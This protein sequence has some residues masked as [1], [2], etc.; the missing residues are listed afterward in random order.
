MTEYEGEKRI[1]LF[2]I[3]WLSCTDLIIFPLFFEISYTQKKLVI[4]LNFWCDLKMSEEKKNLASNIL[5]VDDD[6][7]VCSLIGSYLENSGYNSKSAGSAKEMFEE[8]EKHSF[9]LILLDLTLPDED[10]LVLARKLRSRSYVPLIILT[11]RDNIDDKI[12]ALEIG[13]D[14]FLVKSVHPKEFILRVKNL[15]MRSSTNWSNMPSNSSSNQRILE[16]DGW[17]LDTDGYEL[18]SPT[19]QLVKMT[20]TEIKLLSVLVKNTGRVLSRD[21]LLDAIS[22]YDNSPSERMIDAFVSRIRRKISKDNSEASKIVTITGVG[23][24]FEA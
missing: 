4:C 1:I 9:D 19:G 15:L 21:R 23:Y 7:L 14:D 17:H 5:I 16:F 10:G 22:G 2:S 3:S 8:L 11:A 12:A 13:V 24:K 20:P 6:H 18:Q